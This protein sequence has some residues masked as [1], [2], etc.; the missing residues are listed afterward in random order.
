MNSDSLALACYKQIAV[1]HPDHPVYVVQHETSRKL[2]VKKVLSQYNKSVFQQ[3]MA[4]PVMG[5]PCIR[6]VVEMDGLLYVIEDYIPGDTLQD[7]LDENG[8]F[9]ESDTMDIVLQ[10]CHIVNRLHQLDPPI[11]HRDIK[12]SNIILTHEGNVKLLDM[13]AARVYTD[14]KRKDTYLLGTAGY[15]APEQYGFA[16]SSFQTDIFSIGVLMN[17]L[18]TGKLPTSELAS[19]PLR[20]VIQRCTMMEPQKRYPSVQTLLY[21][22]NT[23]N[24]RKPVPTVDGWKRYLPPGFRT[25]GIGKKLLA[26]VGYIFLLT[27]GLGMTVEGVTDQGILA[28]YR[29]GVTLMLI[30]MVL[31]SG[32]YLGIQAHLPLTRSQ[33]IIIRF[34]GIVIGNVICF[35]VCIVL[36]ALILPPTG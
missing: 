16:E 36:L 35:V 9:S 11:I 17:V 22:L 4:N 27:L 20:P 18:L 8:S 15:A 2:Y 24:D 23:L 1:L 19:G 33:N 21:A 13:N 29:V 10:L 31:F 25:G 7:R 34:I 5:T 26:A 3:L 32:N 12:P 30:T 28:C 6:E 14:E